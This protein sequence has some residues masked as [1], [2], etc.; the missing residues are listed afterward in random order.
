MRTRIENWLLQHWYGSHKPPWY[1]RMLEPIY[2]YAYQRDQ[3]R[4]L[5]GL[6]D[7]SSHCPLIVVGNIT[8]GGS[9][10]TPLVI[11][12]CL[13]AKTLGLAVGIAST[14]YGRKNRDTVLVQANSD[15]R[16]C[17]DEPV[18]LAQRTGAQVVVAADRREAVQILMKRGVGLIIS[19][20]GLQHAD[21]QAD[22]NICV[23]DGDRGLGN[24]HLIPAGPLREPADRLLS[25]DHVVSNGF[26]KD[27]PPSVIVNEMRLKASLVRSLDDTTSHSLDEF[28]N[29]HHGRNIHAFAAIGNPE[30][31]FSMLQSMGL[32]LEP[33]N[34]SDHHMFC[35]Q[36]FASLPSGS[37]ILMTE[38]DAVKCRSLGLSNAWYV[39][40]ETQ[41]PDEFERILK[42]QIEKLTA[43]QLR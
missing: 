43:D 28:R 31:F 1:L 23:V 2:R 33:H 40:L 21:L 15:T 27:A 18:M 4:Q 39:P 13:L 35:L 36:D 30:R 38:K 6:A 8:T 32:Q 42:T 37:V 22:I 16:L 14:G 26:W 3:K 19:D 11:H 9:G 7:N 25:V 34:F 5:A 29:L 12:L 24:G 41:L 20:D 17:G 10:K